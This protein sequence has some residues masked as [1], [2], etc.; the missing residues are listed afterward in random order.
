MFPTRFPASEQVTLSVGERLCDLKF[1]DLQNS[2][3]T[4]YSDRAYGWPKAILVA[5]S[6][7]MAESEL[8]RMSQTMQEFGQAE[9]HVLAVTSASPAENAAVAERLRLPYP[10]FSNP[11]SSL[12]RAAGQAEGSAPCI[13]LFDP[14]LRLEKRVTRGNGDNPVDV[15]LS[16][17]RAR[18]AAQR[19]MVVTAQP[20]AL[21]L[22]NLLDAEHCARLIDLWQRSGAKLENLVLS[23]TQGIASAD[24]DYKIRSDISI[25]LDSPDTKA[26]IGVM[27]R[28]LLPEIRKAFNFEATRFEFFRIGCYDAES[29][30]H[31]APHRDNTTA[32][33]RHRR[34]ALIVN[35]NT[36]DYEGGF[37]R[38]PEY[39]SQLY[40]PPKGGAIVFSCSVLH[41]ATPVIKGRRFVLIGFFW[42]K[43]EQKVFGPDQSG[44]LLEAVPPD[45]SA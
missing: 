10:L 30:G 43:D 7:G 34:Y 3:A 26:L 6:P 15:A 36:G 19:P 37:L 9:T 32:A 45:P 22:P 38:L 8:A 29:G 39:G 28:R 35:L 31:F 4:L 20:P 24:A 27:R 13:L 18:Y 11:D 42:G 12:L 1:L 44:S 41:M 2:P 25:P 17:V 21:V 40:A 14:L 5:W 23:E 16:H 33:V